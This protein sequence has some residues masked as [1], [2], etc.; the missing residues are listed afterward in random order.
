MSETTDTGR[1]YEDAESE[2]IRLESVEK[3]FG[4]VVAVRGVDLTVRPGEFL[5]LLGPSGCGKT[6]T[7]RMIAGLEPVTDGRIFIGSEEVTQTL[8]QDRDVSMVFQNYALYPHK[9]V[10]ENLRFP[11]RKTAFDPESY[12]ERVR[13]AAELLEITNLLEKYPDQLSGGQSQRVA[14]GRTIVREPKVFLLDEPLSNLDAGLRVQTRAQLGTLQSR[15]GTTT[16]YVTHDQEEALSLADRIAIMNRGGLEQV[17]TP[18]EVYTAPA[19]EFVAGFLG[20]PSMNFVPVTPEGH[21]FES[22]EF[23]AAEILGAA[24]P[25]ATRRL[26]VRPEDVYLVGGD[27]V[28]ALDPSRRSARIPVRVDV[29]EPLGHE[30]E[31][32]LQCAGAELTASESTYDGRAADAAVVFDTEKLYL[33]DGD[34]RTIGGREEA[35][36]AG[37]DR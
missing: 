36:D 11:L 2:S 25:A 17:G 4:D 9:T 23:P 26:G 31:L 19:N 8:P 29:V 22:P 1:L 30:Y 16:V 14:V 34:G 3:R 13:Q 24:L 33:F 6:T 18:R 10:A 20:D 15:L 35:V 37:G 21:L 7:L 27:D 32:A 5:V 28:A 12:D